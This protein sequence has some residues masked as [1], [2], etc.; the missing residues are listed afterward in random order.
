MIA[1][2]Q[3]DR[4]WFL[5]LHGRLPVV[6]SLSDDRELALIRRANLDMLWSREA[7]TVAQTVSSLKELVSGA[8]AAGRLIPLEEMT[9]W[10]IG[11]DEG[12]GIAGEIY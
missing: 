4:C 12:M 7:S 6:T 10:K 9:P 3:C 5:N 11:D 1:P 8:K 2:F